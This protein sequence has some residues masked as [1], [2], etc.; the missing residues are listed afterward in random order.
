MSWKAFIA[1]LA[2]AI[3]AVAG[4]CEVFFDN[5]YIEIHHV[6]WVDECDDFEGGGG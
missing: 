2:A 3:A 6:N 1:A 5:Y 4:A